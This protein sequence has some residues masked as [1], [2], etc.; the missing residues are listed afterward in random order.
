MK[1]LR[2]TIGLVVIAALL[3][4]LWG[5]IPPPPEVECTTNEDCI[6]ENPLV[7]VQYFCDEGICKTKPLGNPISCQKDE[8]CVPAQCCHPDSCINIDY[9]P[10]CEGIFCTMECRPGTMDC[11]QGRCACIDNTCQVVWTS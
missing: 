2:T 10:N 9:R 6:P 7:G 3:V 1:F 4:F 11:G 8:D 5:L